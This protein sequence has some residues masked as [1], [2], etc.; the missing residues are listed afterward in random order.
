MVAKTNVKAWAPVSLP[1][2]KGVSVRYDDK[3]YRAVVL[4]ARNGMHLV[5][6]KDYHAGWDEWVSADRIKQLTPRRKRLA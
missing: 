2:G 5:R 6:Y 1:H 3:W 4:A